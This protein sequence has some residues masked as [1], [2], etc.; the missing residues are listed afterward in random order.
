MTTPTEGRGGYRRPANPAPV[1]GPGPLARRTDGGPGQPVR[2]PTG[3]AYGEGV[4]LERLQ[5]AAPL[6]E[7]PGGEEMAPGVDLEG[8][9]G[10]GE[11]SGEPGTPVTAGA[12]LGAGPGLE[13]LGLTPQQDAD[14]ETLI[15]YLPALERMAN[16]P[17]AS[18]ATRNLVRFIKSQAG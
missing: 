7:S 15:T 10:F 17:G 1:S 6:A 18:K 4:E 16:V 8:L 11:P 5:Q 3:G 14:M 2:T 9:T 13:A 12:E